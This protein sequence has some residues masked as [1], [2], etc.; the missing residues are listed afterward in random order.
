MSAPPSIDDALRTVRGAGPDA[1]SQ[2]APLVR[3]YLAA[4]R[5]Y[6]SELHTATGSGRIV[7]EANSDLMDRLVRR[8]FALAEE[9]I[10]AGGGEVTGGACVVAVGGYA[11]REMSIHSDVDLL[12]L[13]RGELT[14]YVSTVAE[15]LQYWL[16]DAGLTVGCATRTTEET[17]TLGRDDATVRTCVLTARFLCGD[18]EFFH[19]FTDII[20]RELLPDVGAFLKEQQGE[21]AAAAQGLRRV[22]LPAPAQREGGRRA[23]LRDYHTAYWSA[24]AAQ[25]SA[26]DLDD[27]L[28]FGLLTE[29]EMNEY[30]AALDFLWR[31]RNA[32]HLL[33]GRR[34]DQ[35]SFEL[36][37]QVAAS[38]DYQAEG[39]DQLPVEAFMRDYYRHARA[40][41]NFSELVIEQCLA[42]IDRAAPREVR[43]VED[44]F[45]VAGGQLEIPHSAHLRED[46]V[47]ILRAFWVAQLHDIPLSRIARRLIRENLDLVDDEFRKNPAC[48]DAFLDV[49]GAEYRVMR[50]LMEMNEVGLLAA[51]LPEW[52]HIVCRWQ[53]VI[54]H[55]Y[56]VDV[57]S[58]FLVEEL[59]RLGKREYEDFVPDLTQLILEAPDKPAI[60]LGCM[61]HDIGKGFGGDHSRIGTERAVECL[62]ALEPRARAHRARALPGEAAPVDEPPGPAPGPLGPPRDPRV[63]P[64]VRRPR[65]P[66]QPVP[67][68]LRRHPRV[69][70]RRLEPV[71][72][73]AAAR[74]LRAHG[75]VPRGG[76]RRGQGDRADRGA[77]RGAPRGRAR[78]ADR[79]RRVARADRQL[80]RRDAPAPTTCP[81]R[82]GRSRVTRRSC[83]AIATSVP[84][85]PPSARC[86]P[87]SPSSSCAPR[88]CTGST[89]P[90]PAC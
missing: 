5:Q 1:E 46:P 79:G 65:E 69:L 81:T 67:A 13:Y 84:W 32:L 80:L 11:R 76:R 17:V 52:E 89:P 19:D 21:P 28:H 26:R 88:T 64:P 66:A 90:S 57:H 16:W 61:L 20:R 14:P 73:T 3:D 78:R 70:P 55:T 23:R 27:L 62:R 43:E 39:A 77:R 4:V 10:L 9:N 40:I 75:G 12:I 2:V 48:T 30:R 71:A 85:R 54:Y 35:M 87:T 33:Q 42:R 8:L 25:P 31:V 58:I 86:A 50:T 41:Q 82:R 38:L 7:N 6:L 72:R 18:G 56:T 74:A 60:F 15:R 36:Q 45:R 59:R 51:F 34:T 63:R 53:H 22:A 37:E 47:R 68:D 49:L 24:R 29:S 83:C 44:G